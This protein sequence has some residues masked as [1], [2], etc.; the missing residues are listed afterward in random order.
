[1]EQKPVY[2][3]G[4]LSKV[5][6]SSNTVFVIALEK[7]TIPD[8]KYLAVKITEKNGGRHFLLKINNMDIMK[9]K[10]LPDLK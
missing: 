9:S 6:G 5:K 1:M 4:N 10:V 3:A 2:T 7:F 8:K